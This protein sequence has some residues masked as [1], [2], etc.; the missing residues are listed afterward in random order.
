MGAGVV[1]EAN[2]DTRDR[3]ILMA[4]DDLD[5]HL[6]VKCALEEVGFMG[7]LQVVR[8][9]VELMDFLRRRGK[10]T[11]AAIPD[12]IILDLNMPQKDGRSALQEIH[13]DPSLCH[14]PVAVLTSSFTEEDIEFCS[15]FE[16][17]SYNRK[18]ATYQE[19]IKN[20]EEI[21]LHGMPSN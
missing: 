8:D 19:W 10:Y 7:V 21:L 3:I 13:A 11:G 18:P 20:M 6:V 12:L 16:R 5:Y 14:I 1:I 2:P 9:G 17:C 4:D 15:R